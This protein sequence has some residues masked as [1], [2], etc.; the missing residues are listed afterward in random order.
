MY[1]I[2]IHRHKIIGCIQ[3]V[4]TIIFLSTAEKDFHKT[5]LNLP[6]LGV[7]VNLAGKW[8]K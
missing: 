6:P 2:Y 3:S 1:Q 8:V 7:I 4:L 5:V